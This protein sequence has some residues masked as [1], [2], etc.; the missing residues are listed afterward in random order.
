MIKEVAAVAD[1]YARCV[2]FD[3]LFHGKKRAA[4]LSV[5][6]LKRQTMTLSRGPECGGWLDSMEKWR[7]LD[8]K[9]EPDSSFTTYFK[10]AEDAAVLLQKI[11]E[12]VSVAQK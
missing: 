4:S 9:E 7:S 5:T 11:G 12:V 10:A 2:I 6:Y 3:A 1:T 8:G